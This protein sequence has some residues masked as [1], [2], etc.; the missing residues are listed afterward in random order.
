M[1]LRGCALIGRILE[2][3]LELSTRRAFRHLNAA[4]QQLPF[5][6]RGRHV[7]WLGC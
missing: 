7:L 4:L 2:E 3:C 5:D 6:L 1:F